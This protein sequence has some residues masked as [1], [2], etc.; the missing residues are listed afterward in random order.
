M[1]L[2]L[3]ASSSR[4]TTRRKAFFL[5]FRQNSSNSDNDDGRLRSISNVA[6]EDGFG[7]D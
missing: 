1:G 7:E 5:Q 4:I 6:G 2:G 3:E